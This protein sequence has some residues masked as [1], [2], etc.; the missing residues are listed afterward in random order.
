MRIIDKIVPGGRRVDEQDWP[1]PC[2]SAVSD[3]RRVNASS[4]PWMSTCP[5][6]SIRGSATTTDA[7]ELV[8]TKA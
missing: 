1:P 2:G 7:Q 8:D 4:L 6:L 3:G 5:L